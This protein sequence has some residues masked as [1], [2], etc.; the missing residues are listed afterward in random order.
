[1]P[2][3]FNVGEFHKQLAGIQ[4]TVEFKNFIANVDKTYIEEYANTDWKQATP[5]TFLK[6]YWPRRSEIGAIFSDEALL[7]VSTL[8]EEKP[9]L[10]VEIGSMYGVSTRLL[11]ALAKRNDA[12]LI[13]IDAGMAPHVEANLKILNLQDVVTLIKDWVPW[14]TTRPDYEI[15]FLFV[16]GDHSLISILV[17][18]HYFNYYLKK[19][20]LVAFHDMNMK[21][22]QDAVKLILERDRLEHVASVGRLAIYRKVAD[23]S[24]KYFQVIKRK[25]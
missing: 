13:T 15:D 8:M 4:D 23:A 5:E 22:S 14:L 3:Q 2:Y 1:M 20:G 9:K 12:K 24:E 19:G 16:D 18:Y 6:M 21:D 7:F 10:T 25:D 11:A 17:D